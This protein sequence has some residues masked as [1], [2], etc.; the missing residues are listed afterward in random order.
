M[1]GSTVLGL[2]NLEGDDPSFS[3]ILGLGLLVECL[4]CVRM[5]CCLG[6]DLVAC[7]HHKVDQKPIFPAS[8]D[9]RAYSPP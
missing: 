6:E 8:P 4:A 2:A 7:Q 9:S 3:S 5:V 1:I